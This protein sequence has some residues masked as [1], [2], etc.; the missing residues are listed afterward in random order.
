MKRLYSLLIAIIMCFS[1]SAEEL[2]NEPFDTWLPDGWSV[3]EGPGSAYYS[4]WF[5]REDQFATVYVTG[6]NQDEW[7]ISPRISVIYNGDSLY[8]WAGSIGG[9]FNDS[10]KVKVSTTNSALESFQYE[11]GYFKVD[12]PAGSW[13]KYGFDLSEFDSLDIYFAINYYI[14]DGGPGGANSDYV[15]VDHAIITG[16]PSTINSAPSFSEVAKITFI[17]E[18]VRL[19]SSSFSRSS[20]GIM[21]G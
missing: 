10:I 16:D 8:F 21:T 17:S 12:G 13:H 9:P 5:N 1:L 7:L 14:K 19:T 11:L 18:S 6:D 20:T 2:I 3:I 4:H 15:W